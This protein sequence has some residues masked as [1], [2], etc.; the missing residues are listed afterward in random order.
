MAVPVVLSSAALF[1]YTE[2]A[3]RLAAECG[4]DGVELMVNHDRRS[5]T[6]DS[7]QAL[8]RSYGLAVR[9]VHVPCLVISQHVWGWNPEVKLRRSVEMAAAV[10]AEIVVVHPPF[11]WQ[12][13]YAESFA[14][15]VAEI[16]AAGGPIVTVENMY[17]IDAFGRN[18][19]PY[20]KA[21]DDDFDGYDAVTL[22]S[23]HAAAARRD[24]IDLYR[25]LGRRV[26]H[27]HLSDSTST[28]GDEHLPIGMGTLPLDD[29]VA[30]IRH[31]GFDGVAVLEIAIAR[32]P[33]GARTA[34]AGASRDW[35][36]AA[37]A[38]RLARP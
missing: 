19:E 22:D 23:S 1:P 4:Y 6:V 10:D 27:L 16:N 17:T 3:F 35:A 25:K 5:Q 18:V 15:L 14:E 21:T 30:A 11:R 2:A 24:V 38:G 9:S 26:R 13:D 36:V 7:V 20:A 29:L 34:T 28:K 8:C 31:D 37:F 32:L 33:E 12:R